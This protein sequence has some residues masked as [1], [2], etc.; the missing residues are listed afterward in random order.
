L[1]PAV[2]D[3][4]T[5]DTGWAGIRRRGASSLLV[6]GKVYKIKVDVTGQRVGLSIDDVKI[7]DEKLRTP[8]QGDQIGVFSWGK[9]PIDFK[10]FHVATDE[11][12]IFVVMQFGEP[13]DT[14]HKDVIEPVS[15]M[16]GFDAYRGDDVFRTGVVLQDIIRGIIESDAIIADI[17]SLNANVFYELG[18]AHAFGKPTI[19]LANRNTELPFDISGFRVIFYEDTIGGKKQVEDA[20]RKH[21]EEIRKGEKSD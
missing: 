7:F 14:L 21:L 9:T 18:Y 20:L 4:Y 12:K 16:H 8:P 17:S 6:S 13:Y 10:D 19:L 15:D 2:I 11:P 5:A 3:S 1:V